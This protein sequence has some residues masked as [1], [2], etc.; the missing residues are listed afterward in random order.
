MD[1]AVVPSPRLRIGLIAF[2]VGIVECLVPAAALLAAGA[3]VRLVYANR[4]ERQMAYRKRLRQLLAA[5]PQ[6][7]SV[8]HCVSRGGSQQPQPH[9]AEE[10]CPAGERTT[11]GR[12]DLDVLLEVFGEWRDEADSTRF[13]VV[14]TKAMEHTCWGWLR[15]LGLSN[16][17]LR[18][19]SGWRP[20]VPA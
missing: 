4:H 7:L 9:S 14:G 12:I 13:L 20:L 10:E 2:G 19:T 6:T 3:E 18:G 15:A 17:L 16:Q 11:V 1:W 8:R 5:Y